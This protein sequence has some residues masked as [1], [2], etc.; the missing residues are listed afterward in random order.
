MPINDLIQLRK[1]EIASW[2]STNPILASGEPGFDITNNI[3]KIGD[4]TTP[5][6]TLPQIS[7]SDI[8]VYAKNTTGGLLN[9]GQA[10]YVSGAQGDH[11][12]LSLAIASSDATSALTLGLLKQDINNN[13]FGYVVTQGILG[14]LNTNSAGAAGDPVW[15]SPT[16]SGGLLYGFNNKPYAPNHIVFIGYVIRKN[17]NNGSIYINIQNGY[18]L[19]ELHNVATTGATNGQFLQYNSSSNLWINSSSGNFTTLQVNGTNVSVSGHTHSSSDIT[20]FNSSVSGLVSGIYAPL[21]GTLNQFANTTSSQLSSIIS[22]ETGSGLLVFNNSPILTGIPLAPTASSGTNTNQIA[23]TS[24]VR[25]EISNLINFAPLALDT[26]NEL[27]AALGNDANFSTTITNSLAGKANLS[28][29][30]FTG[31][32]SGPSG[33]FVVL[34]QNGTGVSV[35]GHSHTTSDIINFNESIDDRV[36]NLLVGISGINVSYNDTS[37]ILYIAYTG[38]TGGGGSL[39]NIVEDTTPQLGGNLDLNNYSISG[40]SFYT[41]TTGTIV[42]SDGWIY[43]SG[44]YV[45]SEGKFLYNGDSQASQFILRNSTNNSASWTTLKNNG[46]DAIL[47]ASNRTYSFTI[48][49]VGRSTTSNSNAAYKLEGLL[50]NDGYGSSIIGTPIKTIIGENNSSWDIR[51]LISGGGSGLSDYLLT[52]VAGDVSNSINWIAKVDLLEVGGYTGNNYEL[53]ILSKENFIP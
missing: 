33:D 38:N 34:K 51:V 5:W 16:V 36:A 50:Y 10:V 18:E 7:S 53:N 27:A 49:I 22:D 26:L 11:P 2:T 39:N 47:L 19:E 31:A 1:G 52:Q 44:Q 30:V 14:G 28:G 17:S 8:Y 41:S 48:N 21:T 40:N 32:V 42:G 3:L 35:S 43:Q 6:L 46:S 45:R 24:F 25:T 12:V 37:N 23:S 20:N 4:G 9:K 13:E 29:A 15:L